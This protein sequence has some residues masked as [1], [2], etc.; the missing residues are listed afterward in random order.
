MGHRVVALG[1]PART[2][3]SGRVCAAP[4]CSTRLSIYNPLPYCA[5][6]RSQQSRRL[7]TRLQRHAKQALLTVCASPLCGSFFFTD[8][9][10][11]HYCCDA[12]RMAASQE[13]GRQRDI[14]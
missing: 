4:G 13:R 9:P 14:C 1:K 7:A 6:H 8:N 11:R 10:R 2:Y 3:A 5:L 12:C